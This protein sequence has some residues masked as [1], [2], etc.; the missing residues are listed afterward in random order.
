M[1]QCG[2][3]NPRYARLHEVLRAHFEGAAAA[4]LSESRVIVFTTMRDGVAGICASL[5]Q[6]SDGLI[7][8]R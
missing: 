1:D 8:A 3:G 7:K 2:Q 6:L 5:A 4:C